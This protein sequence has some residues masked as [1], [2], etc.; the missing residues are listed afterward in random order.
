MKL[1]IKQ[2]LILSFLLLI[3]LAG[4]IFYLGSKNSNDLHNWVSQIIRMHGNRIILSG[5]IA[6]DVQYM[7]SIEKEIIIDVDRKRLQVLDDSAEKKIH[8]IDQYIEQIKPLLDEE[9]KNDINN[10]S[11]K[12]KE[13]LTLFYEIRRLGSGV[14]TNESNAE[15][16]RISLNEAKKVSAEVIAITDEIIQKNQVLLAKI[17]ADAIAL[18]ADGQRNM[19][20]LFSLIVI[21]SISVA[22]LI[23]SSISQSLNQA[24][25]SIKKIAAGDFSGQITNINKDEIGNVLEHINLTTL[26]L[27]ES[28]QLA[29]KVS[30]G[31]LTV[32]TNRKP[33][34]ELEIA[35]R[36][37]VIK[38][39]DIVSGI[40]VGADNIAA[41][42][43]QM[44][45]ASQQMSAGA[46]EQ[47]ASAEEVSSSMEEMASN[48]Q[49]NNENAK[50]TEKIA[51]NA[52]EEVQ[53]SNKAVSHT[54]V[55]MKE[56]TGKI[57]I[58]GEIARQTN[59]LALNAAIEAARAGEQ[60]KGF[61]V[62]A[63]EVR[64]LAERSQAA[65]NDI[66][67]LSSSGIE[68][69]EK[70]G[71]LL[72]QIVPNIEKTSRLVMDISASSKEQNTGAEQINSALQQLSQVIQQN[73]AVSEELAA[74]SAELLGQADQLKH[75]VSFFRVN[76][77]DNYY[78]S[79]PG[80]GFKKHAYSNG[81]AIKNKP[82]AETN[83]NGVHIDMGINGDGLDEE[84][85]RF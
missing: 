28:A 50:I 41:A 56:I 31:D 9:G 66:N 54:V 62:V 59:L 23:V 6:K 80:G 83:R 45:S 33:E 52:A 18:Y 78:N 51:V 55:S 21:I 67:N 48:I 73:A 29:K 24:I 84:Y 37:M 27:Q 53:Q 63:A 61:A 60:G 34:G 47:A 1:T 13:Y 70:S 79:R 4:S 2:R 69:A 17:D 76:D 74:S 82:F 72:E 22:Y 68:I 12:W 75:A 25:T 14:N 10:F 26:K 42:S 43:Q 46:T 16:T 40:M 49:Q 58:I 19:T 77:N 81:F 35:L 30:E 85:E 38:L 8:E 64:K 65:A 44:N 32:N 15:A 5:K 11:V 57:S 20:I 71:K 39:R 7:S 3:F 36:N